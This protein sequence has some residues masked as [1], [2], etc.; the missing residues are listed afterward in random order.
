VPATPTPL[1]T[2]RLRRRGNTRFR[3]NRLSTNRLS[4]KRRSRLAAQRRVVLLGPFGE[5]LT[6]PTGVGLEMPFRFS[7]KYQDTETGLYSYIFRPYDPLTGR[8]LSRDPIE[9]EG[10]VNLYGYVENNPVSLFDRVGLKPG[11][12][13]AS[14][15]EAAADALKYI[16]SKPDHIKF[17][18]GGWITVGCDD[19]FTYREPTK[20][21]T[22]VQLPD[23]PWDAQGWYHNHIDRGF[24]EWL[25]KR[26]TGKSEEDF[27]GSVPG[28]GTT[29]DKA[30]SDR[31]GL[32]GYLLTPKGNFKKYNP[33]PS[34]KLNGTVEDFG[35]LPK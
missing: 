6:T 17:E 34:N 29:G 21:G 16:R 18:Y 12:S 33:D 35:P 10:G 27:S 8:W 30:V 23:K 1:P 32:P 14:V 31:I 3:K 9:E 24:A 28:L 2:R 4:R 22:S 13:F 26:V 5:P 11:D 20:G 19:A 15:D 7:T 25:T